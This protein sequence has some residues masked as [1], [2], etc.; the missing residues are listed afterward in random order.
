MA[1]VKFMD[2]VA[3]MHGKLKKGAN[4]IM[5]QKKY[6]FPNGAV[7]KEGAQ[8]SYAVTNPRDYKKNPPT[9]KELENISRFTQSK[10]MAS[11]IMHSADYSEEQLATMTPE[12]C[13]QVIG[14]RA[15]LD[16]FRKRFLAQLKHP[17]KEAPF[18]KQ[19]APGSLK[20]RRKQYFRLDNFI[21]AIILQTLK[22]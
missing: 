7:F 11:E 22:N 21:Q 13:A 12:Q 1:K 20:L 10:R 18:E 14:M 15:Q 16:T 3:E 17:D 5:R 4:I 8:E 6:R 19:P 2:P 9:G